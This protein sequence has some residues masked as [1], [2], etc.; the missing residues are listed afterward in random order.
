MAYVAD[1]PKQRLV[2]CCNENHCPKCLVAQGKLGILKYSRKRTVE[3]ILDV[4]NS[5]DLGNTYEVVSQGIQPNQPFWKDLSHSDIFSCFAPDLPHQLHKG[6]FKD[7]I[8]KWVMECLEGGLREKEINDHFH[9]MPQGNN[10]Q[11][12]QKGISLIS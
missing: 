4:M 1:H 12:F 10:L 8:I 3:S 9:A 11:H 5:A 2:V 7:C 6:V